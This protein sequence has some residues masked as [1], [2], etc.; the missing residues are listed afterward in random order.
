[1]NAKDIFLKDELAKW[2]VSIARD[3]RFGRVLTFARA[4]TM[5]MRP[6]QEQLTGA[7]MMLSTLMTLSDNEDTLQKF[8]SPGLVHKMPDKKKTDKPKA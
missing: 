7:E 5:E 6:T 8:P 1:M 4:E 2:W 3:D